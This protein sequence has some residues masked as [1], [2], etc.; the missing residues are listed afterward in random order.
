MERRA[1]KLEIF[2]QEKDLTSYIEF[3]KARAEVRKVI[4]LKKK[5]NF[6]KFAQSINR[7]QGMTYV[8]KKMRVL[9]NYRNRIEWNT[10]QGKDGEKEIEK[11]IEKLS[12]PWAQ[13][14]KINVSRRMYSGSISGCDVGL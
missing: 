10:W 1:E 8:W 6:V 7:N 9:K 12:T 3:K 5:E 14:Q 13:V 4:R 11:E 2:E